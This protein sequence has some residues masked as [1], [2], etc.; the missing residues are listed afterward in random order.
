MSFCKGNQKRNR[1]KNREI[2]SS[3]CMEKKVTAGNLISVVIL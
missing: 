3:L 2:T 1:L